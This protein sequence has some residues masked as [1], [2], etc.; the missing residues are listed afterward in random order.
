MQIITGIERRR[1]WRADEKPR[2]IAAAMQPGASVSEIAR[3]HDMSR[4]LLWN[5][6]RQARIAAELAQQGFVSVKITSPAPVQRAGGDGGA[7]AACAGRIEIA[8]P[9][10]ICIRLEGEISPAT[11]RRVIAALRR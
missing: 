4:A 3:R 6:R 9:D 1:R 5:W 7:A 8:F 2:I 10:G 11:L